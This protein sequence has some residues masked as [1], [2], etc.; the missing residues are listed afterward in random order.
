MKASTAPQL[1][2]SPGQALGIA[3][4]GAILWRTRCLGDTLV[5]GTRSSYDISP[6]VLLR[7]RTNLHRRPG[8]AAAAREYGGGDGRHAIQ[9]RRC[10]PF[11]GDSRGPARARTSRGDRVAPASQGC[12]ISKLG[13]P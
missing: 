5:D 9:T 10:T 7:Q 6:V 4:V 1:L 11:S 8:S 12:R 2:V 3:R 13:Q